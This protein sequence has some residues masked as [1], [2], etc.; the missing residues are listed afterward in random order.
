MAY[1]CET[2]PRTDFSKGVETIKSSFTW[3]LRQASHCDTSQWIPSVKNLL[4]CCWNQCNTTVLTS[5][6]DLDLLPFRTFMW[7]QTH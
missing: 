3:M 4:G 5:S 6:H 7:V 2:P 1:I